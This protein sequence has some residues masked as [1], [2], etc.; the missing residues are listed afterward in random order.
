MGHRRRSVSRSTSSCIRI[1]ARCITTSRDRP[2]SSYWQSVAYTFAGSAL[3]EIA[4]ETTPPSKN[5]QIASGIAGTF[6]GEPLFRTSRLLLD[7]GATAVRDSGA[8]CRRPRSSPPAGV[9]RA[10]VRRPLRRQSRP[11]R[12]RRIRHAAADRR[13]GA[14]IGRLDSVAA[15]AT[16]DTPFVGFSVDYGF[17]GQVATTRTRGRSTTSV[18]TPW[19]RP[20]ALENLSTRG[21]HRRTRLRRRR[22]RARRLGTLRQLRL[23]RARRV[24]CLEHGAVVRHDVAVARCATR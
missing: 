7:R 13:D 10:D 23:L 16:M 19:R 21:L 5:D 2:G 20:A 15:N 11:R 17:P 18:S 4:G 6:L 9:N 1:R 3:W 8:R 22:R 14:D 12:D 24:P